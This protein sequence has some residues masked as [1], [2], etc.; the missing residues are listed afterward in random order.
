MMGPQEQISA[1]KDP[2]PLFRTVVWFRPL[3]QMLTGRF[4]HSANTHCLPPVLALSQALGIQGLQDIAPALGGP[5]LVGEVARARGWAVLTP[6]NR[7]QLCW[8][9]SSPTRPR[10]RLRVAAVTVGL[11]ETGRLVSA[12][13][14]VWQW[15]LPKG[16]PTLHSGKSAPLAC[17]LCSS[18]NLMVEAEIS[19][20]DYPL[21]S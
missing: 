10:C 2:R 4:T 8:G 13:G 1:Q 3:K 18:T 17:Q 21:S 19:I 14:R 9:N 12:S 7:E 16:L 20:I 15:P 11:L 6:A 5:S